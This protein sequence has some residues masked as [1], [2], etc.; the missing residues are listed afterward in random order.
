MEG[1]EWYTRGRKTS[2]YGSMRWEDDIPFVRP[3][4]ERRDERRLD[5]DI[6]ISIT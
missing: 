2:S 5:S 3:L 6:C 4:I 1:K